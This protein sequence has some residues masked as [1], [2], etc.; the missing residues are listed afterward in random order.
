MTAGEYCNREVIIT[1][2][3][4]TVNE[5]ARLMRQHHVGTLVVVERMGT[6]NRPLGIVTDRDLVIEVLAQELS[7]DSVTVSDVMSPAPVQAAETETLLNTIALM[8][9]RGV[10]RIIVVDEAGSLQGLI[11]ADD[12]IELIAEAM[13]NL[14]RVVR[15]ELSNEQRTYP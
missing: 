8:Q 11:S 12:V 9:S 1:G 5:A 10:R 14:T 3:E 15:R 13:D 2:P 6:L 7:V 4:S